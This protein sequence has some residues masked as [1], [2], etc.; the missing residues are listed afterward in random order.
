LDFCAAIGPR[1]VEGKELCHGSGMFG[2]RILLGKD[3]CCVE[4][5][6]GAFAWRG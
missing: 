4:D 3:Y 1:D 2:R 5:V 6:A